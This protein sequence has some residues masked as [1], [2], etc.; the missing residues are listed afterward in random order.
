LYW[1]RNPISGSSFDWKMLRP[2]ATGQNLLLRG[3]LAVRLPDYCGE[4][5][6]PLTLRGAKGERRCGSASENAEAAG[7]TIPHYR[8]DWP[9]LAVCCLA[10][11]LA[12]GR[13]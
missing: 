10:L 13:R 11:N 5:F 9:M 8:S 7:L 4:A 12:S 1:K 2:K 3:P 6:R